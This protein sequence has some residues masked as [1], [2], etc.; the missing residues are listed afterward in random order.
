MQIVH[1]G[2]IKDGW[3]MIKAR[4]YYNKKLYSTEIEF[5]IDTGADK[6]IVSDQ[7]AKRLGLG[8][9][10]LSGEFKTVLRGVG[11]CQARPLPNSGL[12]FSEE[13]GI[14]NLVEPCTTIFVPDPENY[15]SANL[16]GRDVLNQYNVIANNKQKLIVLKRVKPNYMT[17]P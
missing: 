12:V 9:D 3:W 16:L 13:C 14:K 6:T 4:L 11:K 8:Y 15:E 17:L 1:R 10:G 2:Y 7:C 5:L